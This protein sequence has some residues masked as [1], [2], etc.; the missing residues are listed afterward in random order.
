MFRSLSPFAALRRAGAALAACGAAM[1][2]SGAARAQDDYVVRAL[3]IA[4]PK[5]VF[6]TVESVNVVPA[7]ARIGGV[8]VE[9][10]VDEGDRVEAGQEIALVAS[11]SLALQIEAINARIEA[12][13]A[14]DSQAQID[15]A[16]AE[17]LV[18]RGVMPRARLDETR[19]AASV[20]RRELDA[21]RAERG[22]L[23]ETVSEGAVAAPAAGRV[24]DAPV[25]IGS[26]LLPGEM[27]ASVASEN[28]VLRLRL[29]ERHARFLTV[30]A[31]VRVDAPALG[32]E[33]AAV[34]RIV[35]VY[36]QIRDG[37]VI[38]DAELDGLGDFFVGERVR[39]WVGTELRTAIIAPSA[40]LETRYGVDFVRVRADG[41]AIHEVAVQRGRPVEAEGVENGVEILSGLAPGDVLVAP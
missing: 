3:E 28:Y 32:G 4:D 14:R 6:A 8:L 35:Q 11:E 30:G 27:V 41:D 38:A 24:L 26:V 18:G 16:R 9:L 20:A 15:L 10:G 21:A 23:V 31:Q 13:A 40:F 1:A 22:V 39:V 17:E 36:P 34:A 5:A 25:T 33:A 29:P 2:L 12:A 7:R 37:R 19:T